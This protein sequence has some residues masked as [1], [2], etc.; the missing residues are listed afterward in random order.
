[1]RNL[2]KLLV[3]AL[4]GFCV[5]F[6][7]EET[8]PPV[9]YAFSGFFSVLGAV[10][11]VPAPG[12]RRASLVRLAGFAWTKEDFCRGWL[13]T[14]DTGS[15]KTLSGIVTLAEQVYRR[16]P[17]VGGVVID[18]KGVLHE[19]FSALLKAKGRERDLILLQTR[20]PGAGLGWK[21]LHRY[22][23]LSDHT[24]PAN[25]LAKVIVDT[26]SS[27]QGG[28]DKG[29]FRTNVQLQIGKGIETLR[30]VGLPC[31]LKNLYDY[32][33]NALKLDELLNLLT[34]VP[35]EHQMQAVDLVTHWIEGYQ[36][37]PPEQLGGVKSTIVNYLEYFTTPEIAEIFCPEENSFEFDRID[38]G[39]LICV[40]MPQKYQAERRYVATFLKILY[41]V[42]LLR[43]FDRP[44]A[45]R[46]D[47]NLLVLWA[48]EAQNFVTQTEG[49]SDH[50]TVDRIREA[51]G[52]IVAASQ[53]QTSFYPPLTR[54]KAKVLTLNLRNR[55]I[56]KAA[57]EECA[58]ESADFIGKR[59]ITKR[60][61]GTSGGR[62]SVN[63]SHEDEYVYK[64][65]V[66]RQLRTHAC[67]VA[68]CRRGFRKR[69]LPPRDPDG[70]V[71]AWFRRGG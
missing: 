27:I 68:H 38:Q 44:K 14:G 9:R 11:L 10:A 32:L 17:T 29:F 71:C 48:D 70:K 50:S 63:Y 23:L 64:P 8:V 21:P 30:L 22:N 65:H 6:F 59:R 57:D 5:L 37:Q 61:W 55:L 7:W 16:D 53:S 46:R 18:D 12:R 66:L 51:G 34:T 1:M 13:I 62:G 24:I 43:R 2:C 42:H 52:T 3:A 28:G 26:A 54:E 15:G 4:S 40:S 25:T 60:S 69:L 47:D 19:T 33:T 49:I 45:Q 36:R 41:Y 20:P 31:T 58:K 35:D 39:A 67:I 56:F